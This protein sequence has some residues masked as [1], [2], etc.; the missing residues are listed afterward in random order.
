MRVVKKL[1]EINIKEG[2]KE[3]EVHLN[4]LIQFKTIHT[5]KGDEADIV[6]LLEANS[7]MFPLNH[8]DREL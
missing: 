6:F 4:K 5:V 3:L 2:R 7:R 1:T 8:P